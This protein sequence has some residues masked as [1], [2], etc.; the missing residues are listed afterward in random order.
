MCFFG[1][2]V[3]HFIDEAQFLTARY[4]RTIKQL[5]IKV[6]DANYL[7]FRHLLSLHDTYLDFSCTVFLVWDVLFSVTYSLHITLILSS[8]N[9]DVTDLKQFSPNLWPNSSILISIHKD[10]DTVV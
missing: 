10:D 5:P 6:T 3:F 8:S 9:P 1:Y 7:F 2:I 4:P